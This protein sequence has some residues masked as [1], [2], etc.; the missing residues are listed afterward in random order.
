GW[1]T[2]LITS[3]QFV[4]PESHIQPWLTVTPAVM[5][6]VTA[7]RM[8]LNPI[9]GEHRDPQIRNTLTTDPI[10]QELVVMGSYLLVCT[11]WFNRPTVKPILEVAAFAFAAAPVPVS[12]IRWY[13][14]S[15]IGIDWLQL[16]GH[17]LAYIVL[18]SIWPYVKWRH[19]HTKKLV[20]DTLARHR[21][22][23]A[24]G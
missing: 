15:P 17:A 13:M 3:P 5:L 20:D 19:W 12:I 7:I 21:H 16:T 8:Q 10:Q 23:K 4:T 11:D 18:A 9:T 1:L 22:R 2:Y 6:F 14:R 24:L